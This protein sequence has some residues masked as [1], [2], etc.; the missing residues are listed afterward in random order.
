MNYRKEIDGLRALAV[1]AVV[2]F[3]AGCRFFSGGFVGVDI[4]FVISGYLITAIIVEQKTRGNFSLWEFYERRTRRIF[5]ALFFVTLVSIPFAWLWLL[6]DY[7]TD[8]SES[9]MAV[10]VFASNILFWQKT[11]YVNSALELQPLIH[12]WSLAVEEQYYLLFPALI[13]LLWHLGKRWLI[14]LVALS[15]TISLVAAEWGAYHHPTAA[16]FLM[17]TRLWELGIGALISLHFSSRTHVYRVRSYHHYVST[18]GL[19][20]ILGAVFV[21]NEQTPFPGLYAL[22]PTMGTALVI[23]CGTQQTYVGRILGSRLAVRLGLV[24]YSFYLWHQPLF[25]FAR[26]RSVSEPTSTLL[27]IMG[28]LALLIAFISWRFVEQPFRHA[29]NFSRRQIFGGAAAGSLLIFG[30]GLAG[31]F[32]TGVS[33]RDHHLADM[34]YRV[35]Q[36][37]GLSDVCTSGFTLSPQC[38]TSDHPDIIVWGDSYAMHLVQGLLSSHPDTHLMQQTYFSC[39][40][41]LDIAPANTQSGSEWSKKCLDFNDQVF[42]YLKSNPSIKYVVLSSLLDQYTNNGASVY[43]RDTSVSRVSQEETYRYM[44]K[45]LDKIRALGIEPV[46][47]SPTPQTGKNFGFCALKARRFRASTEQCDFTLADAD[48]HRPNASALLKRISTSYKVIWLSDGVCTNGKCRVTYSDT[49]LYHDSGH[50]S[51]DGSALLGAKM[52]LY[53]LVTGNW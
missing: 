18:A 10:S 29:Q 50:L 12:T 21:F 19:A 39:G 3:H 35:R 32:T 27:A 24:S 26:H 30:I 31:Y 14:T 8:F 2:L 46:I 28:A 42:A 16:F 13:A 17:P 51:P 22:V 38:R 6:P 34:A 25:V 45:T 23:I 11:G 48:T 4:F 15:T 5:P 20:L 36:N 7:R 43:H 37:N 47:V 33:E 49:I 44:I 9:L 40:P 53:Q 41:L 52:H 1:I